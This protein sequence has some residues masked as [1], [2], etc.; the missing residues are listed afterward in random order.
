MTAFLPQNWNSEAVFCKPKIN[1]QFFDK[2]WIFSAIF[3][4]S[5]D[6]CGKLEILPVDKPVENV[7]N[8]CL[9][10]CGKVQ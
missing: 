3:Q 8:C 5:Y 6:I 9:K 7:D 1:P 4:K 10:I 2:L